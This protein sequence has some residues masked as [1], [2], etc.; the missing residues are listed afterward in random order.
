MIVVAESH[1]MVYRGVTTGEA[2]LSMRDGATAIGSAA[3]WK[4]GK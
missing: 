3:F 2:T 4:M 1:W